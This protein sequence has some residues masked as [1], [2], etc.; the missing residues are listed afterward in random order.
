M[1]A[2]QTLQIVIEAIDNASDSAKNVSSAFKDMGKD[3]IT[4]GAGLGLAAAPAVG[5]FADA[6]NQAVTF[7][8]AMTNAQAVLGVTSDAMQGLSD[9]ILNMGQNAREGPQAVAESYYDIVSGVSDASTH[10]AIL[11][12]AINTSEAGASELGG[13]TAALVSIMNSYGFAAEDAAMVSDALTATVGKGVLTMDEL[14]SA[15]PTVTGL[16]SSL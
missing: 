12:A 2:S 7:N 13:T 9:D 3:L 14:A 5:I 10:M 15:I 4:A 1:A 11:Q 6:A 8:E 16:A